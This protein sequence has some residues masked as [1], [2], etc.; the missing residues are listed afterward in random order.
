MNIRSGASL[1]SIALFMLAGCG[2]EPASF[3]DQFAPENLPGTAADGSADP[4][5]DAGVNSGSDS[6]V[7]T[8]DAGGVDAGPPSLDVSIGPTTDAVIGEDTNIEDIGVPP[9][10]TVSTPDL[11][12]GQVC[13]PGSVS[14]DDS[15]LVLLT[16]SDDGFDVGRIRCASRDAFCGEDRAGNAS[17]IEARCEPGERICSSDRSAVVACDDRGAGYSEVVEECAEGCADDGV[18]CAAGTVDPTDPPACDLAAF[19]LLTPGEQEFS[20]CDESNDTNNAES[21]QCQY[22]YDGNDRTFALVLTERTDVLLD[23]RDEDGEAAIDTVLYIR[24]DCNAAGSQV[25]CDDDVPCDESDIT[26]GGCV[27]GSQPRQSRIQTTLD[28]GTYYVVADQYSYTSRR[29]GTRFGCGNVLLR[30]ELD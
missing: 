18:S 11:L 12:E 19:T 22:S 1:V 4:G 14:C 24:T 16:C 15:G 30:Y 21:D 20:L 26:T 27:S 29:T 28:A 13:E 8:Q 9:E 10:D 23:L 17:C 25:A 6:G 5:S 7:G 2:T 3:D